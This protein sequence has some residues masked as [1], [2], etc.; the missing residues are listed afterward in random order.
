MAPAAMAEAVTASSARPPASRIDGAI[1]T[2]TWMTAPTPMP[3]RKADSSALVTD[4]PI[5]AP[6]IAGAP[7]MMPRQREAADRRPLLIAHQR[8]DDREA[9]GGVVDR[10]ADHERGAERQLRDR[11]GGADREALPH[12]VKADSDRDHQR[13]PGSADPAS[14]SRLADR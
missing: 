6:R 14:P 1:W 8:R 4:A 3:K 2:I 12:V 10:E 7:A 13:E 5:T 9:L 11:V